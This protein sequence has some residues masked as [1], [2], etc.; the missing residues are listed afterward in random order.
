MIYR[1]A[2][3]EVVA[4]GILPNEDVLEGIRIADMEHCVIEMVASYG[5]PVGRDVFETVFWTGRFAQ[6][7]NVQSGIER[8]HAARIYRLD[9]KQQ[10][11]KDSRAKDSNIRQALIDMFG[12]G[13]EA[14]VGTKSAPGPLYGIKKD[15]W[16]ALAVAVTYAEMKQLGPDVAF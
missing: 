1:P 9:V 15:M 7:W 3:R 16:A 14:A 8:P 4:H 5:M 12:P 6:M 10:L 2:L 13:K 11:C